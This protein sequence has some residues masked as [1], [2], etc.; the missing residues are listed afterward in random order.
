MPASLFVMWDG[1]DTWPRRSKGEDMLLMP[2]KCLSLCLI[3][4]TCSVK[5]YCESLSSD[6]VVEGLLIV[7]NSALQMKVDEDEM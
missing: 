3:S 1:L 5:R 4:F 6:F 7:L 2:V